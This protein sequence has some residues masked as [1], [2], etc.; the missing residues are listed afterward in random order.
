[1]KN[2]WVVGSLSLLLVIVLSSRSA[3]LFL[4]LFL[5][6]GKIRLPEFLG[7]WLSPALRKERTG[8]PDLLLGDVAGSWQTFSCCFYNFILL[9]SLQYFAGTA[10]KNK[11]QLFCHISPEMTAS[12][13]NMK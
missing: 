11:V 9:L 10:F 13:E 7:S 12:V 4:F 5:N 8:R 6:L 2:D 3:V 1:M